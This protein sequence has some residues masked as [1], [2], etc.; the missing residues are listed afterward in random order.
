ME[1]RKIQEGGET[2]KTQ[3]KFSLKQK[4]LQNVAEGK[5]QAWSRLELLV[6]SVEDDQQ[7]LPRTPRR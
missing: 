3:H 7:S 6:R 5:R 4:H 1:L 2:G